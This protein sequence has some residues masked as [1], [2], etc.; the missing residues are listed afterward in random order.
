LEGL[1]GKPPSLLRY[2]LVRKEVYVATAN[3]S[4]AYQRMLSEPVATQ[5]DVKVVQ[6]LIV[7]NHVLFSNVATVSI[8]LRRREAQIHTYEA[9]RTVAEA[10]H[11]LEEAAITLQS[12]PINEEMQPLQYVNAE[13]VEE[14]I[15]LQQQLRFIESLCRDMRNT[16]A[17]ISS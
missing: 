2:K 9:Q 7:Q 4:A 3:L 6:Q 10:M 15:F 11:Y 1:L 13:P 17:T 8:S 14:D 12:E 16:L 5:R